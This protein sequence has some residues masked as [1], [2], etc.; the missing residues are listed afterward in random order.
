MRRAKPT[1]QKRQKE[2]ARQEKKKA[3]QDRLEDHRARRAE[4]RG[5]NPEAFDLE[6]NENLDLSASDA[7]RQLMTTKPG[8]DE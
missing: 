5:A 2:L 8:E 4:E 6:F 3:K 1:F 7:L